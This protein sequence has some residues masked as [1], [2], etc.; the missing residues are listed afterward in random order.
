MRETASRSRARS[1]TPFG[2]ATHSYDWHVVASNG[3]TIAD[4]TGAVVHVQPGQCR[5]LHRHLYRV[6]S[7]RRLGLGRG[8]DHVRMPSR[9]C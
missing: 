7:E 3:Q 9:R 4:G 6:G 8:A 1:S 2:N 5:H